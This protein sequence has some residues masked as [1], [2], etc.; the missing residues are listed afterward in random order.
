MLFL[1][2]GR[3]E[4]GNNVKLSAH[5]FFANAHP[6]GGSRFYALKERLLIKNA[7]KMGPKVQHIKH[8]CYGCDGSGIGDGGY[9]C[10]RCGGTGIYSELWV[11]HHSWR[12]DGFE[13]LIPASRMYHDPKFEGPYIEGRVIH[14]VDILQARVS[15]LWLALLFDRRLFWQICRGSNLC[16]WS[17]HPLI[18]FNKAVFNGRCFYGNM[19][20]RISMAVYRWK[21][22]KNQLPF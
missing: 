13:F 17:W 8:S 9:K 3:P 20:R 6:L 5:L 16:R 19:R 4:R 7:E 2:G 22:R 14:R 10:G 18:V 11:I 1:T 21:Y 12:W 15:A